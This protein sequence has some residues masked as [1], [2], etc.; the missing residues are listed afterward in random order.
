MIKQQVEGMESIISFMLANYY[1][2]T[3]QNTLKLIIR[4]EFKWLMRTMV[5]LFYIKSNLNY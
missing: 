1:N 2:K 3:K 5:L 4:M